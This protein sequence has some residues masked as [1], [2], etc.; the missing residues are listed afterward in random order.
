MSNT[1]LRQFLKSLRDWAGGARGGD[2]TD[3][4]L[5]ERYAQQHDE[6]AFAVL[7]QRHGQLVLGVSSRVLRNSADIEDVFQATFV[8]LARKAGMLHWQNTVAPWLHAVAYRLACKARGEAVR[9]RI[10]ESQAVLQG[11]D[12]PQHAAMMREI[13]ETIDAELH[14]LSSR[15]RAPLVL[16]LLSGLTRDEAARQLNC[17]LGTLKRRLERGRE[18][19][20]ARLTRRGLTIGVPVAV[21]LSADGSALALPTTLLQ[22]TLATVRVAAMAGTLTPRVA[23]LVDS[24]IRSLAL[25]KAK[26]VLAVTLALA[27]VATGSFAGYLLVVGSRP[28][29]NAQAAVDPLRGARNRPRNE[30]RRPVPDPTGVPLPAGALLRI[31]LDRQP[32]PNVFAFGPEGRRLAVAHK[33]GTVRVW[34]T[35]TGKETLRVRPRDEPQFRPD[36]NPFVAFSADGKRLLSGPQ[37]LEGKLI[38]IWDAATGER[39][40]ELTGLPREREWALSPDG[41]TV[42]IGEDDK[43]PRMSPQRK[44][45][46][47]GTPPHIQWW[48][49]ETCKQV[50]LSDNV[51]IAQ[52]TA[53]AFAPDGKTRASLYASSALHLWESATGKELWCKACPDETHYALVAFG[54]SGKTIWTHLT[55]GNDRADSLLGYDAATGEPDQPLPGTGFGAPGRIAFS[56]DDDLVASLNRSQAIQVWDL[57]ANQEIGR[58][59]DSQEGIAHIVFASDGETFATGGGDGTILVWD[60]AALPAS[61]QQTR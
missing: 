10:V 46:T 37:L 59:P 25:Q 13:Q 23:T 2:L 14:A 34:D 43:D 8:V 32:N 1:L 38:T 55:A 50:A 19:L 44:R 42:A 29:N 47:M 17:S 7:V 52:I 51:H 60:V 9:R 27:I 57:A 41:K 58:A 40:R 28:G 49:L 36:S 48:D 24:M 45:R 26:R 18:L 53:V 22:A 15:Y 30:H 5:L 4:Q 6:D 35:L 20:R 54:S 11:S 12:D 39:L 16:C 21:T 3:R 56:A 31:G 33:D 61:E